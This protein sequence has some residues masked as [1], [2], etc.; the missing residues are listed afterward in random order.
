MTTEP[1]LDSI[2]SGK[3]TTAAP[4]PTPHVDEPEN[5]IADPI[6][7]KIG[8]EQVAGDL[9]L[10]EADKP[11]PDGDASAPDKTGAAFKGQR[12]GLTKRYTEQVAEFQREL[13]E[14]RNQNAQLLQAIAG[15]RQAPQQPAQQPNVP[16]VFADQ[17]AYTRHL[18]QTVN[19]RV[20][21]TALNFDL[22]LAEVKHRDTFGKAWDAFV[23]SV[24][25]GQNP[26]LYH[27]VMN[28]PSP[29]EAIVEWFKGE[30][31]KR[32]VGADPASYRQRLEE[33]IRAKVLAE[34]SGQGQPP[35]M[36]PP[37]ANG[38][39]AAPALPSNFADARNAG[40]RTGPAWAGAPSLRDIFRK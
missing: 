34:L 18:E 9:D 3:A 40:A 27:Q 16:D 31:L 19:S 17:E 8:T 38:A 23:G 11:K 14:L 25:T 1:T 12:E 24:G 2:L 37:V 13:K 4:E 22:K 7:N 10:D 26:A 20:A 35:A 36:P 15:Q 6:D 33:E 32:E 30:E 5:L 21:Q 29:G 39:A 28:A